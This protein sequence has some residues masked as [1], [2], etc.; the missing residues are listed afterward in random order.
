MKW[1]LLYTMKYFLL[2]LRHKWFVFVAGKR[3]GVSFIRLLMHDWSK[4]LPD[5]LPYYGRQF[6]GPGDDPDGYIK[7]WLRHQ[8]RHEHHWE[9]WVPRTGH[10]R[11]NPPYPDN[12]PLQ[13]PEAAVR[14]MI[15]DW[16]GASRAYNGYWPDYK[17]W[18][19]VE[20]NLPRMK[21]H[22]KTRALI[23]DIVKGGN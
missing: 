11:C 3:F 5:E 7:C 16:A 8:N 13:M 4:F 21:L 1:S 17:N 12:E 22:I 9:Y 18:N 20:E 14:E 15:A 10:S 2:T 6:C 19:W 23:V